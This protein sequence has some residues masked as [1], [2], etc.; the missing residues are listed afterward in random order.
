MTMAPN[1]E[2]VDLALAKLQ[3]G[4]SG[5]DRDPLITLNIGSARE[6]VEGM[7]ARQLMHARY[8]LS[9][10][11]FPS[12]HPYCAGSAD[13]ESLRSFQR[14]HQAPTR[15]LPANAIVL[16]PAPVVRVVSI[17]YTD[18]GGLPQTLSPADYV[19]N[20]SATP[21]FIAPVRGKVWPHALRQ[22]GSVIITYDAGYASKFVADA[23]ADTLTVTSSPIT[24]AV[25]DV[26]RLSNS[27]G[28]L[29]VPL[30]SNTGYYIVAAAAGIYQISATQGGSAIDLTSV[31]TGTSYIG[32][33]PLLALQNM[34]LRIESSFQVR[35]GVLVL[36]RGMKL[37]MHPQLDTMLDPLVVYWS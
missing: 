14:P 33:V 9:M 6:D 27:G 8:E 24:W 2:P 34:L 31:G 28:A 1:A 21:S 30:A 16:L 17:A 3:I 4:A 18:S 32:E 19:V 5:S 29:P 13:V 25:N 15:H 36:D 10:D 23:T 20:L 22:Q 12:S 26:V 35:G 37:D 7:T 11:R